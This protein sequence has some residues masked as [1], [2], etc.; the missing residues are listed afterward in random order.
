MAEGQP[1]PSGDNEEEWWQ[2]DDDVDDV[3]DDDSVPSFGVNDYDEE[4]VVKDDDD[5]DVKDD[6]SVPSFGVRRR[7]FVNSL[8]WALAHMFIHHFLPTTSW[9]E[10]FSQSFSPPSACE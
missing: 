8:S 7:P 9:Q 5:D 1:G 4:N 6:D 10:H 3:K 2:E